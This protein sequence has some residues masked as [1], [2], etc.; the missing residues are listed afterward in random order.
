MK[1]VRYMCL[2][3]VL[4]MAACGG[5]G[6]SGSSGGNGGSDGSGNGGGG[7]GGGDTPALTS[8]QDAF[9]PEKL[10]KGEDCTPV[11]ETYCAN[12]GSAGTLLDPE[13][14]A[15]DGV[16]VSDVDISVNGVISHYLAIRPSGKTHFDTLYLGLHYLLGDVTAFANVARLSELAKA[17]DILILLPQAPS[18][19]GINLTAV[20]PTTAL[21]A[22][23]LPQYIDFLSKVVADGRSRFGASDADLYVAGLSN[24]A[25]MAYLFGCMAPDPVRAVL[26]VAGDLGQYTINECQPTHPLGT[27]IVHGTNDLDDP[28]NGIMGVKPAIPD[29]HA[30]FKANNNCSGSDATVDAPT[31]FDALQVTI[32]YTGACDE[33]RR[34]F[35]VTVDEGGH[36]WPGGR[37]NGDEEPSHTLFGQHTANFDA[38]L[39]GFDL[40]RLA[41]G[42]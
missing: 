17:R 19:G 2:I 34:D 42:D 20:W 1:L 12:D 39:Q 28:Y 30:K 14:R 13:V 10:A 18:A 6:G 4:A 24:G 8:C 38:T 36:V 41:G 22:P 21:A 5:S 25:A 16:D 33:G 29:I 31:Y 27:V 40:L 32:A 26:A 3:A 7:D 23:F 9:S 37:D 15:C 35:L 11:A